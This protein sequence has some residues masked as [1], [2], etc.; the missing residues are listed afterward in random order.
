MVWGA[1]DCIHWH[2]VILHSHLHGNQ[3]CERL[4]H[5]GH[6]IALVH[7]LVIGVLVSAVVP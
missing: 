4:V 5:S 6:V 3:V 2:Q 7:I 1:C